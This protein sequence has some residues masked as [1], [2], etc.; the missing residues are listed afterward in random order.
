VSKVRTIAVWVGGFGL[1]IGLAL[2]VY[3]IVRCL[4]A[5]PDAD[6]AERWSEEFHPP[7]ERNAPLAV[8]HRGNGARPLVIAWEY[9]RR[10]RPSF[11]LY[12]GGLWV[13]LVDV[14]LSNERY[15]VGR[16]TAE[17]AQRFHRSM[18]ETDLLSVPPGARVNPS[19]VDGN[20]MVIGVR[21][22]ARWIVASV[23]AMR[24][25]WTR[26][27]HERAGRGE[28]HLL[29]PDGGIASWS[30]DMQ[31]ARPVPEPF[32]A[33]NDLLVRFDASR[34]RDYTGGAWVVGVNRTSGVQGRPWPA[35]LPALRTG[36]VEPIGLP[37]L[38]RIPADRVAH[39]TAEIQRMQWNEAFSIDG[40]LFDVSLPYRALPAEA[41]IVAVNDEYLRFTRIFPPR[42]R[43]PR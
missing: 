35:D 36:G 17:D 39:V 42:E 21:D 23:A 32:L 29:S 40:R 31:Y 20:T 16:V 41:E 5:Q 37:V 25:R 22:R 10:S 1:V 26:Q 11:V 12:E 28:P 8:P 18:I 33:A 13:R 6:I 2:A 3:F 4:L 43:R 9:S 27:E 24:A 30:M 19:L 15:V 14:W 34:H 38:M 7:P